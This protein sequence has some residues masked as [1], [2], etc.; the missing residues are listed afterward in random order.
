MPEIKPSRGTHD[1]FG[2]ETTLRVLLDHLSDFTLRYCTVIFFGKP[3]GAG[4]FVENP[5]YG[6][7][8][9][10]QIDDRRLIITNDHVL[11]GY[12]K[13]CM[14]G[15]GTLHFQIGRK[16][17]DPQARLID[18]DALLDICTFAADDLE[19]DQISDRLSTDPV[20]TLQFYRASSWPPPM[21]VAG[22][23]LFW[24]G[25][26]SS[27][28]HIDGDKRFT[29]PLTFTGTTVTRVEDHVMVCNEDPNREAWIVHHGEGLGA[30]SKQLQEL[31]GMSGGPAFL[32]RSQA[33]LPHIVGL[34]SEYH[35]GVNQMR[36]AR[37]DAINAD[38][39]LRRS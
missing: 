2:P 12:E 28:R 39:T 29:V 11:A 37:I 7:A 19:L 17:I 20:P 27:L 5:I 25:F 1:I 32:D 36:L 26:P 10:L 21:P 34:I 22:E 35:A 3:R 18:R 16:P 33:L 24:A 13:Y 9:L 23:R 8:T 30:Q 6:T 15:N 4:R 31:G 38:G 14:E